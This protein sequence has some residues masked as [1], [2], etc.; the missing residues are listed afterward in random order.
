MKK[1]ILPLTPSVIKDLKAG[2]PVE[3]SG[4]VYTARDQVH[5]RLVDLIDNGEELPIPL[6]GQTIFYTGPAPAKPGE[7]VGSIGPTTAARMDAM[8]PPLLAKGLKG[9][10]GKGDRSDEVVKAI[11]KHRAVYFAAVGGAAAYLSQFVIAIEV[12]AWRELGPEAIHRLTL[13][14]FPVVVAIDSKGKSVFK[15]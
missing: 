10:I 9:M 15:R 12:V 3:L 1:I 13:K 14:G 11:K 4:E 2:E 7:V 5:V 6:T 8:T